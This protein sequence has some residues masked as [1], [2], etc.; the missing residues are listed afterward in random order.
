MYLESGYCAIVQATHM[1]IKVDL[2][3]PGGTDINSLLHVSSNLAALLID[4]KI[5]DPVRQ[6]FIDLRLH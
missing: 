4:H 5:I 2:P 1:I 3:C 6:S